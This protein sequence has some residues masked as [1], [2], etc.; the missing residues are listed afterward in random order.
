[1]PGRFYPDSSFVTCMCTGE[2]HRFPSACPIVKLLAIVDG[3]GP[4]DQASSALTAETP[5][6]GKTI[7]LHFALAA[8]LLRPPC[9]PFSAPQTQPF[10]NPHCVPRLHAVSSVCGISSCSCPLT[11][12]TDSTCSMPWDSAACRARLPP[13]LPVPP[14]AAG[15]VRIVAGGPAP[16]SYIFPSCIS[17]LCYPDA[18]PDPVAAEAQGLC[19]ISM[20]PSP[21]AEGCIVAPMPGVRREIRKGWG[22]RYQQRAIRDSCCGAGRRPRAQAHAVELPAPCLIPCHDVMALFVKQ[23]KWRFPR[24]F[25]GKTPLPRCCFLSAAC[26]SVAP[27]DPVV[28]SLPRARSRPH[29]CCGGR[30]PSFLRM[31]QAFWSSQQSLCAVLRASGPSA[32]MPLP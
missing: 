27:L 8:L 18:L 11:T 16:D 13:P 30:S 9:G 24:S 31:C 3:P 28:R 26:A 5:V 25:A 22:R 1:M 32:C 12:H 15:P 17:K 19:V 4:V 21:C 7:P 23:G 29:T 6:P 14:C 2:A 20:Q 10:F